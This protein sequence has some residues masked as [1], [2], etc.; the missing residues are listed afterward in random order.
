MRDWQGRYRDP[1]TILFA[2]DDS[3]MKI[4]FNSGVCW[5]SRH[6]IMHSKCDPTMT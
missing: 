5:A 4:R 3:C 1:G 2:G 6:R